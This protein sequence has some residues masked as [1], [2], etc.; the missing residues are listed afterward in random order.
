MCP[1]GCLHAVCTRVARRGLFK[2]GLAALALAA[3][4]EAIK[5][6]PAAAA[7]TRSFSDVL[8]LTHT[9]YEGFPT[10]DGAKWFGMVPVLTSPRSG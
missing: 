5:P 10:F 8:D 3:T 9:L 1:P 6:A 4:G 7:P 2:G